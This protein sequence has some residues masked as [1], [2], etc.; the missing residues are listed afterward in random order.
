[1][2]S[3]RFDKTCTLERPTVNASGQAVVSDPATTVSCAFWKRRILLIAA[4]GEVKQVDAVA[5]VPSGTDV[6]VRDQL[7]QGGERFVVLNVVPA[8]DDRGL[9]DCVADLG[10]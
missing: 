8:D 5:F 1:M 10:G 4:V 2:T 7:V 3:I 6:S 9:V